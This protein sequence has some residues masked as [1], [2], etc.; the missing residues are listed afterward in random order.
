MRIGIIGF[1]G[2]GKAFV[3]LLNSKKRE[4]QNENINIEIIYIIDV[5]GGVH[6][7]NGININ[8]FIN[9]INNGGE[10]ELFENDGNTNVNFNMLIK[11]RDVD[12][13]IEMTHT[14]KE[15]GEPGMT[16][17]IEALKNN[18]NVV[19]SNKGPIMLAYSKLYKIAKKNK[20]QLGIGCTTGGA[21]PTINSGIIELA[22]S[23][24]MEI[25][26]ILNGTTNFI[27]K[28]MQDNEITYEDALKKAKE[29]G[30][31]ETDPSLDVEGWDT[32]IKLLI[33]TNVLLKQEKKLSDIKVEGITKLDVKNV[34]IASEEGKKYKLIG[35]TM[36]RDNEIE[37]EVKLEKI[38][39]NHLLFNVDNKNKG[40]RFISDTLG[41]LVVIGGASGVI[42]AAAS[43]LRDMVNIIKGYKYVN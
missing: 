24:I 27:L 41:D 23:N 22:G 3:N 28:E 36:V 35:K 2:V 26:G 20:V 30:I 13:I 25:E 40:I 15:T 19:T 4:L 10:L 29:L 39:K 7:P 11:N 17:I 31:A 5:N 12:M 6:N 32:A 9:H 34:K 38:D 14:N 21:L 8:N 16:H 37:M 1:G 43:I 33:L 18:I 42:P